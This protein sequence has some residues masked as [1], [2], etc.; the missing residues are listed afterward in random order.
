MKTPHVLAGSYVDLGFDGE[1]RCMVLHAA[2]PFHAFD[3]LVKGFGLPPRPSERDDPRFARPVLILACPP[4]GG[5]LASA[6]AA[7]ELLTMLFAERQ[8]GSRPDVGLYPR[9]CGLF[10]AAEAAWQHPVQAEPLH[11]RTEPL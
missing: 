2:I 8:L 6:T 10:S 1:R 9:L 5:A 4:E 7:V 3:L 11:P